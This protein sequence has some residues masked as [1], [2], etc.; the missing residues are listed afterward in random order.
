M[1]VTAIDEKLSHEVG[2]MDAWVSIDDVPALATSPRCALGHPRTKAA[3]AIR[4]KAG[5]RRHAA[6]CNGDTFMKI[7]TTF[8]QGVTQHRVDQINKLFNPPAPVDYEGHGHEHRSSCRIATQQTSTHPA[9]LDVTNFD[10]PGDPGNPVNTTA[11]LCSAKTIWSCTAGGRTTKAA[12]WCRSAT[13]WR[14]RPRLGFA[15][16]DDGEVGFANNIRAL[17]GLAGF[18]W[19]PARRSRPMRS[20]DDVGYFDEPFLSGWNHRQRRSTSDGAGRFVFFVGGQRHRHQRIRVGDSRSVP[21]GTGF[22]AAPA[23]PRWPARTSI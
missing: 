19:R 10:L 23:T 12:A 17:A 15:T 4:R 16:A 14:R 11:R 2:V 6:H 13:R 8:D 3:P 18:T 1:E 7:G 22:T 21:N 20:A 5:R 9:T